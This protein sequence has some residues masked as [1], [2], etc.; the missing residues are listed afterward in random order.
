MVVAVYRRIYRLTNQAFFRTLLQ[1]QVRLGGWSFMEKVPYEI[2]DHA[3]TS[4]INARDEVFRRNREFFDN[5]RQ[6]RFHRLHFQK[7]KD[8]KQTVT[9]RARNCQPHIIFY[10]RKLHVK[11]MIAPDERWF[12]WKDDV[13]IP[14][15]FRPPFH[16]EKIRNNHGWPDTMGNV[17]IDSTLTYDRRLR[18]WTFNWVYEKDA[19]AGDNQADPLFP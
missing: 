12:R 17:V 10:P 5:G 7:L 2:L 19:R 4:A 9:I 15:H 13:T 14:K 18:Q 11:K 1:L 3:I 6:G 16:H 8:N